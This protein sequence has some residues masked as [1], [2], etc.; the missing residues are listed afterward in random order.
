MDHFY[1]KI[2]GWSKISEQGDLFETI[3]NEIGIKRLNIAEIGVYKGRSTAMINVILINKN[4]NYN[5][6]AIDHF[7]G[8][9]EHV[10]DIDY[11]NETLDN[12]RELLINY[13]NIKII[14]NDSIL[15]SKKYD[16]RY[17]DIVYIDA[18]HDYESVKNDINFWKTKVRKGGIICGDDY[19]SGWP[20]VVEAVDEIF[21]NKI[22][23]VGNQQW[24]VKL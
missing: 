16:D 2:E 9:E 5:Y 12:L 17:F 18:S 7:M 13:Q 14:K 6:F 20:G 24:W 19:I 21:G 1:H 22:N 11:Y 23:T 3:I 4:I 8:S 10:K 15:E